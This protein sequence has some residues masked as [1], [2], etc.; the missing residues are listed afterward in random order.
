LEGKAGDDLM[1]LQDG[2]VTTS[3]AELPNADP[4]H[5]MG[6]PEEAHQEK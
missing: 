2:D 5:L 6:A 1:D 3:G 4:S